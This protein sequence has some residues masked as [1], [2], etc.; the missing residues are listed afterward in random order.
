[1]KLASSSCEVRGCKCCV[2]YNPK[3]KTQLC[4]PHNSDRD[5]MLTQAGKSQAITIDG[6]RMGL[7]EYLEQLEANDKEAFLQHLSDFTV[8]HLRPIQCHCY[9]S[10]FVCNVHFSLTLSESD[11]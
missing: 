5:G 4:N 8:K 6:A 3:K 2:V 1:M 11:R 7:R 10:M 9:C